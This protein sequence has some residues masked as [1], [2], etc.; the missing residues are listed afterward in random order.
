MYTDILQTPNLPVGVSK[1]L[2]NTV[3]KLNC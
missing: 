1:E 3:L 2:K